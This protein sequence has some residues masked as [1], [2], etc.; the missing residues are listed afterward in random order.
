MLSG[1]KLK[2]NFLYYGV[3]VGN[4]HRF[5]KVQISIFSLFDAP[6]KPNH[7]L[8]LMFDL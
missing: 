5:F 6:L 3:I 7:F 1:K 4:L 2:S 8:L